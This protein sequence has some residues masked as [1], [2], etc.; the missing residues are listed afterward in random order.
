MSPDAR[1]AQLD[2]FTRGEFYD[3]VGTHRGGIGALYNVSDFRNTG[4]HH[5]C[6][7]LRQSTAANEVQRDRVE[8]A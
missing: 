7:A 1:A 5:R 4:H 6:W 8:I 2:T 3:D